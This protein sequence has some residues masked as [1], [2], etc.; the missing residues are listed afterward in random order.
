MLQWSDFITDSVDNK[1]IFT[2]FIK[3][4]I[5][6]MLALF[7]FVLFFFLFFKC[8][9]YYQVS[10]RNET[11]NR[12]SQIRINSIDLSLGTNVVTFS[13]FWIFGALYLF[14]DLTGRPKWVL[15]YKIQDGSHQR[16]VS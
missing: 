14:V 12:F 4:S 1:I 15:Q 5:D 6:T 16:P 11:L 8:C 9:F 2:L 3:V 7:A 13:V 10:F